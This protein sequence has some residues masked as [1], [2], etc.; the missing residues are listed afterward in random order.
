[1][2]KSL[3]SNEIIDEF[4]DQ[5]NVIESFTEKKN[6]A[7]LFKMCRLKPTD[8]FILK[9]QTKLVFYKEWVDEFRN[10][11][12]FKNKKIIIKYNY[13]MYEK[14]LSTDLYYNLP[15]DKIIKISK[16]MF[17]IYGTTEEGETCCLLTFLGIDNYFRSYLYMDGWTQVS[18]LLNGIENLLFIISKL[19]ATKLVN[20]KNRGAAILPCAAPEAWLSCLPC[21]EH[22]LRSLKPDF[23]GV[24]FK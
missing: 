8:F 17:C 4:N 15:I 10:L 14:I 2:S 22:A 1:M 6:I 9:K 18:P 5:I 19:D 20:F 21:E 13:I 12:Y 23:I 16:F 7:D 3:T 24:L 11:I